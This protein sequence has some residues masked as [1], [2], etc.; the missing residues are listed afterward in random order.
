[1]A[2]IGNPK[3]PSARSSSSSQSARMYGIYRARCINNQDPRGLGRVLA[4]IYN[5]DGN[6]SYQEDIHQWVPVLSPYGGVKGMGF[7]M[8][9][10]IHAEGFVIFEGGIPTRPVWLGTFPYAPPAEI[11]EEATKAAGY[12]VVK[13]IPT[14]PA[15][16]ENDPTTIVLKTQYPALGDPDVESND[17]KVENLVTLNEEKLEL[18]HV[19]QNEY[20]YSQG[21]VSSSQAS[22]YI[23]LTDNAIT[24]GVKGEDDKVYELQIDSTGIRMISDIGDTISIADGEITIQGSDECQINIRAMD[25]GSVNINGKQVVLDGEQLILGPPG[26]TGGGG[27]VTSDAICPFTGLPTHVSSGK[28]IV[29]G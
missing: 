20:E 10:P 9:P 17:N 16:L 22:S 2:K 21:G 19:N 13:V 15:E 6:L 1:M 23:R 11:D 25:N 8:I 3:L 27:V 7:Y 26:A 5:R 18:L 29:G 14:I 24:L 28:T 4:H 12:G